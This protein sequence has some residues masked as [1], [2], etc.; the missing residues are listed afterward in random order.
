MSFSCFSGRTLFWWLLLI[1]PFWFGFFF[2]SNFN[3]LIEFAP[4]S[5]FYYWSLCTC[6]AALLLPLFTNCILAAE[7]LL[8]FAWLI[9]LLCLPDFFWLEFKF[10]SAT[11]RST[12][13]WFCRLIFSISFITLC[14][15]FSPKLFVIW[16]SMLPTYALNFWFWAS[17]VYI[18]S[19]SSLIFSSWSSLVAFCS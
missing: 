10:G 2:T 17:W 15:W 8:L 5:P 7:A 18:L 9:V 1:P 11:P 4:E 12:T 19:Y 6:F 13:P 14:G 16:P 3:L